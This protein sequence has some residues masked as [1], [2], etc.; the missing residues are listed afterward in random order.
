MLAH[1]LPNRWAHVQGVARTALLVSRELSLANGWRLYQSAWLHDIGYAVALSDSGFHPLD[2]AR[3]IRREGCDDMVAR[4]VAHHSFAIVEAEMRGLDA[5]VLSE[6]PPPTGDLADLL[7]Y[8]DMTTGPT[9]MRVEVEDRLAEIR[10]R[11]GAGH[12]VSRFVDRAGP[13]IVAAVRRVEAQLEAAQS[14]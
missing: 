10:V 13:D 5:V 12:V 3:H 6:F 2:G 8:C 9:G 4:L 1:E 11:Y 14:R 7:C